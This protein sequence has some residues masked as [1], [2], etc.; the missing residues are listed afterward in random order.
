M[1]VVQIK[2]GVI[3]LI[4]VFDIETTGL[5]ADE[6]QT[7]LLGIKLK[8]RLHQY[9]CKNE[10][11]EID[12]IRKAIRYLASDSI[13]KIVGYNLKFDY[14]FILTRILKLDKIDDEFARD[15][16]NCINKS[17]DI[18]DFVLNYLSLSKGKYGLSDVCDFFGID[19]DDIE[20]RE[21]KDLFIKHLQGDEEAMNRIL[22]HN[23]GDL[24]AVYELY[25][26]FKPI[27]DR[28]DFVEK[29]L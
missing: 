7:I 13:T 5:R 23:K 26:K 25:N 21:I 9:V 8:D 14:Q 11:E 1:G 2:R 3:N 24:E 19:K 6:S 22:E 10:K 17:V 27:I 28:L 12:Q 4:A 15:F 29:Q 20:G 16:I 18:F